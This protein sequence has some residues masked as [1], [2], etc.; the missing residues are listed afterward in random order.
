MTSEEETQHKMLDDLV[1]KA[2]GGEVSRVVVSALSTKRVSPKEL[3]EI[4]KLIRD[5]E[6][7]KR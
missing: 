6:R 7:G 4:K 5:L 2:F 1:R 3:A